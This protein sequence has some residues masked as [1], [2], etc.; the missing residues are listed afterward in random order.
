MQNAYFPQLIP[1]LLPSEG[2]RPCGGLCARARSRH[3]KVCLI[4]MTL[5]LSVVLTIPKK[6]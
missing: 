5:S 3:K 2:S 4:L 6:S 1:L